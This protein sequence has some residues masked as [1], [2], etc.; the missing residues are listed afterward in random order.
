LPDRVRAAV[1]LIRELRRTGVLNSGGTA[2]FR[3]V[4]SL[5]ESVKPS[6]R[7]PHRRGRR[8]EDLNSDR[9]SAFGE[10]N[11]EP[12]DGRVS[13]DGRCNKPTHPSR[14]SF[15]LTP[16]SPQG[17]CVSRQT[18]K[19][20]Q[21]QNKKTHILPLTRHPLVEPP[22]VWIPLAQLGSRQFRHSSH[23]PADI[24]HSACRNWLREYR[25]NLP[26]WT[27]EHATTNTRGIDKLVRFSERAA[28]GWNPLCC[29]ARLLHFRFP[30]RSCP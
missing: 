25:R 11:R 6:V 5:L 1:F 10:G 4:R 3:P 8:A 22:C 20:V 28:E 7:T 12:R 24:I 13:G 14:C 30:S 29:V 16:E 9:Q 23:V 15:H 19:L 21:G 18:G 26:Q 2:V 17:K 27:S